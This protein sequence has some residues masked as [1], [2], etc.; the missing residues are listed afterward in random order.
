MVERTPP[1][2]EVQGSNSELRRLSLDN[3]RSQ[4]PSQKVKEVVRFEP[5]RALLSK[6][7]KDNSNYVTF[8]LVLL[9]AVL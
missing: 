5:S 2:Q 9:T 8:V 3:K 6:L 7:N 1:E 4:P